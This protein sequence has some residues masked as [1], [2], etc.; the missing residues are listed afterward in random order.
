M[1]LEH[2]TQEDLEEWAAHPVTKRVV[3]ALEATVKARREAI[4]NDVWQH[5]EADKWLVAKAVAYEHVVV[6]LK[7]S[8]A[9]EINVWTG[10]A[11]ASSEDG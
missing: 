3:A 7:T 11:K 6:A 4:M 1:T 9:E 2:L 8:D 10:S 5:G